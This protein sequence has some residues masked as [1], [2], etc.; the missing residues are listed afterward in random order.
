MAR[1][2]GGDG[3]PSREFARPSDFENGW[4]AKPAVQSCYPPSMAPPPR[5][6]G[7]HPGWSAWLGA[8]TGGLGG[9]VMIIVAQSI[10]AVRHS[11]IDVVRLLGRGAAHVFIRFADARIGGILGAAAI[12]AMLGAPLGLMTRRLLRIAPRLLFFT[13]LMSG[14]W[15]FVRTLVIEKMAAGLAGELPF[16]PLLVGSVAYGVCIAVAAPPRGHW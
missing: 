16:G 5:D 15:L 9:V 1:S 3:R 10:L 13:L 11:N 2:D 12:G 4:Y 14:L 8:L 7:G 6:F